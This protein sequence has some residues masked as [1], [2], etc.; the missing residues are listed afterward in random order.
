MI[1]VILLVMSIILTEM[2]ALLELEV[3]GELDSE[4][5]DCW[6]RPSSLSTDI[7]LFANLNSSNQR[8]FN[9]LL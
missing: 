4:I 8:K 9:H 7:G 2:P 3:E 6:P 1:G 5:F